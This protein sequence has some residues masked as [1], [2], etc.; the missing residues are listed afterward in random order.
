MLTAYN[1]KNK[2]RKNPVKRKNKIH[3]EERYLEYISMS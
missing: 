2:F 1:I 3:M